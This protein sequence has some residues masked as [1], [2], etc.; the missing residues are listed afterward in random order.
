M[1]PEP[2]L[3]FGGHR[4]AVEVRGLF[5]QRPGGISCGFGL[6]AQKRA[7]TPQGAARFDVGQERTRCALDILMPQGLFLFRPA[8]VPSTLKI[9]MALPARIRSK[10]NSPLGIWLRRPCENQP[11][12]EAPGN[13]DEILVRNYE[14]RID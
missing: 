7:Q 9:R 11:P 13:E 3:A 8:A 2:I 5:E 4:A 14:L 10:A 6:Q 12:G 1:G